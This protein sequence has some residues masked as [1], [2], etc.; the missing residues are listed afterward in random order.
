[1]AVVPVVVAA[2]ELDEGRSS[3][4]VCDVLADLT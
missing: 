4:S 3:G 1:M 2:A